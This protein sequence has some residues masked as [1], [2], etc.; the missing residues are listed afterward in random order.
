MELNLATQIVGSI[1][2]GGGTTGSI[3]FLL[4]KNAIKR[5]NNDRAEHK[6]DI[7]ATHKAITKLSDEVTDSLDVLREK[8][9]DVRLEIEHPGVDGGHARPT[10][11]SREFFASSMDDDARQRNCSTESF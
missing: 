6:A 9:T 10:D 4:L 2:I 5:A 3:V 7:K 1:L 8:I 11:Q